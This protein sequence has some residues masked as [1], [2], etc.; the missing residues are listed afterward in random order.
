MRWERTVLVTILRS[1]PLGEKGK[2]VRL[3]ATIAHRACES[4]EA[5]VWDGARPNTRKIPIDVLK[6]RGGS[7]MGGLGKAVG[8]GS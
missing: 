4:G 1:G 2:R 6:S 5:R 3:P 8:D 7:L